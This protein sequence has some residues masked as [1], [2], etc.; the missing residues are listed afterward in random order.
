MRMRIKNKI[1]MKTDFI[2]L[3]I[4]RIINVKLKVKRFRKSY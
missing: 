3:T 2:S 4:Q 1:L